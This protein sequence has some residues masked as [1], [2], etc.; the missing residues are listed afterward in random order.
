MAILNLGGMADKTSEKA[1]KTARELDT[2]TIRIN[3]LEIQFREMKLNNQ[4]LWELLKSSA[5]LSDTA[6]QEKVDA[7]KASISARSNQ[8]LSC[9][10]CHRTVPADK[11]NCYYCGASLELEN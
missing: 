2:A 7:I 8:T 4:A 11:P 5:N 1:E 9:A 6:L 3:Q 10:S